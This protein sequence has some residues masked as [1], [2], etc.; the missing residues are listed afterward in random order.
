MFCALL[1]TV[2][3]KYVKRASFDKVN[4]GPWLHN[5]ERHLAY[6]TVWLHEKPIIW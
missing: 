3:V 4:V 5:G 1:N 2:S 6:Y